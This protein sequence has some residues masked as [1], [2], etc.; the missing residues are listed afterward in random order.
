MTKQLG[1]LIFDDVEELDAIGPYEVFAL[2]AKQ[3]QGLLTVSLI[4][5]SLD[6]VTC[7]NGLRLF[8]THDFKSAPSLDIVV[9]PGGV[10]TRKAAQRPEIVEW[11]RNSSAHAEWTAS[12]CSGARL[13]LA[14]GIAA[15]RRITTHWSVIE[16]L[17]AQGLAAAVL[18]DVRFVRDGQLVSSAGISAGI[19]M[20]LWL[21][22][23]LADPDLARSVQREMEYNPAPPYAY[24]A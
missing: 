3:R 15:G 24:A 4:A 1:I 6:P 9:V 12:V 19:D 16:E 7:V 11:V 18:D 20:S 14:A 13:T 23:Q 21:V 5:P 8:P 17:R 10:G 2:A 22:G